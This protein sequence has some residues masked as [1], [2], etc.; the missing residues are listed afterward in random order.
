MFQS[1][2]YNEL[3]FAQIVSSHYTPSLL[4]ISKMMMNGGRPYSQRL[5]IQHTFTLCYS[6]LLFCLRSSQQLGFLLLPSI[7][8]TPMRFLF[9]CYSLQFFNRT[10]C[11]HALGISKTSKTLITFNKKQKPLR[12][13]RH[14]FCSWTS[15]PLH[16]FFHMLAIFWLT[17]DPQN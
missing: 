14:F 5:N 3:S 2:L 1:F 15:R 6:Q 8:F 10:L 4:H 16:P 13:L 7:V 17:C 12:W 9:L 11:T